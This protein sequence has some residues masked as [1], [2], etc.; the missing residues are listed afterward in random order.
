MNRIADSKKRLIPLQSMSEI[1]DL[2]DAFPFSAQF[3]DSNRRIVAV[4]RVLKQTLGMEDDQL[5]GSHCSVVIHGLNVPT[6]DCPL[7]EALNEGKTIERELFDSRNAR[8]ILASVYPTSLATPDGLPLYLHFLRDITGAKNTAAELS[9]SLEHHKALCDLLQDLQLNQNR[10]QILE[11]LIDRVLSLSWLGMAATAVGFL[12]NGNGLDLV[13]HRNVPAD[14]VKRCRRLTPGECLCGKVLETGIRCISSSDS[15]EHSINYDGMT[16]HQHAVLPIRH[17]GRL[18]GVLTL[19]LKPTDTLDDF[20]LGFLEAAT[21]AAGAA[22]D[23]QLVREQIQQSQE[24]YLAQVISSQEDERKRVAVDLHDQL[25]QSLSAILLEL[26]ASGHQDT[27]PGSV[28]LNLEKNVREL[29]DQVR[30]MAGQLRPAILDDFGL[31]SALARKI[32]DLSALKKIPIDYQCVPSDP[33]KE[34]LPSAVEI[35]L[36]RVAMEALDNA[37]SH[38][39]AFH[40]S[41]VLL[42]QRNKATLLVEDDG[43][44]FD[45]EAVRQD[46]DHCRGLIGME[47]RMN[48]LGGRLRIES[49]LRK[50]TTVRAEVPFERLA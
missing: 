2:L 22:L 27:L 31:E 9:K 19:Y 15:H 41:V 4:N 16:E 24:K 10:T 18:L 21:A 37:V 7:E 29:I 32:E 39:N 46:M 17:K 12:V 23:G 13:T 47:E 28:R 42:W 40:I 30:R 35:G 20:R 3:I 36:Y 25:C 38:S 34:R 1:Q 44:G 6:T 14:L 48:I 26:H 8:W 45:Y 43:C 49:S 11:A 5:I 50:G 33:N